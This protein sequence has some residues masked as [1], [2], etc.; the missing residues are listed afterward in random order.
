MS[1]EPNLEQEK[2]KRLRKK[3][4]VE[5]VCVS[6]EEFSRATGISRPTIYRMMADGRL[7]FVQ[8]SE[9]MRKIP[10]SEYGRLG[11]SGEGQ[12]TA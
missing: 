9:R 6:P 12:S 3:R 2:K 11:L 1:L 4:P 8:A 10:T 7:R 5:C